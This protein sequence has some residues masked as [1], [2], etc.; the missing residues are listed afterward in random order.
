MS[1]RI[2]VTGV[3]GAPG[4]D[5]ARSLLRLGCHVVATDANPRAAGLL[6]PEVTAITTHRADHPQFAEQL[7]ELCRRH[8][9]DALV[10]AVE[11]D[12]PAVLTLRAE[13]AREGTRTWLPSDA[14]VLR[15]TDKSAFHQAMRHHGIPTPRT[16]SSTEL[17]DVPAGVDL[18][19]KPRRGHGSQNVIA[20][21]TVAQARAVCDVVPDPLVQER[22]E[23]RE[24]TADAIVDDT[25][26]AS[27]ILRERLLVKGGLSHAGATFTDTQVA[28]QVRAALAAVQARGASCVQGFITEQPGDQRVLLTEINT[29]VAGGFP[30][31]EAAGADITG[32]LLAGHLGEPIDHDRLT[33]QPGVTVT[34]YVETLHV[35]R[36]ERKD[37]P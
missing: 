27:V 16:W 8:R 9:P 24:F 21:R 35:D 33:Y 15:C 36:T 12:L 23:G 37:Y 34:R 10:S 19:V 2:L 30:I 32:Q 3:G 11:H 29:R 18:V 6:L 31:A 25:G 5:L 7:L 17:T 22:V 20:C 26:Q 14:A 28:Q 4:L 1:R 13:L